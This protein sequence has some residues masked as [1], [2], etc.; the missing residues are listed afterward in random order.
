MKITIL[1]SH[2]PKSNKFAQNK[3]ERSYNFNKEG[4]N[5]IVC[6]SST[7]RAVN[8]SRARHKGKQPKALTMHCAR[9]LENAI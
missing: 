1:P 8:G 6:K 2:K 4:E 3:E 5:L 9:T 7:R